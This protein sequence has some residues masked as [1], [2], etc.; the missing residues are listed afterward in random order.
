MSEYWAYC[1]SCERSFY[2]APAGSPERPSNVS[3]PVCLA[4]TSGIEVRGDQRTSR[5]STT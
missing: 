4:P 2:L 5:S 3:C 1:A